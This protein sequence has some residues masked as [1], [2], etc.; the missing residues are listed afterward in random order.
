MKIFKRSSRR[1]YILVQDNFGKNIFNRKRHSR[2][3][4]PLKY[5]IYRHDNKL[6]DKKSNKER[7]YELM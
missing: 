3:I 2:I 6:T 5:H 4:F 7:N 1:G